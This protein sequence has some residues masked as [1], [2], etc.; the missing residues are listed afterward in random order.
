MRR[1][2]RVIQARATGTAPTIVRE[3]RPHVA[4]RKAS[5]PSTPIG[6]AVSAAV[7]GC[8]HRLDQV[9]CFVICSVVLLWWLAQRLQVRACS[10]LS[11]SHYGVVGLYTVTSSKPP[12]GTANPTPTPCVWPVVTAG[13]GERQICTWLANNEQTRLLGACLAQLAHPGDIIALLGDLGVGKTCVARGFLREFFGLPDLDVPS[14][15]FLFCVA[16]GEATDELAQRA[17]VPGTPVFHMDP[18]RLKQKVSNLVDFER[19]FRSG[20]CLIEWPQMLGAALYNDTTPGR[21]EIHFEG[22]GPQGQGRRVTLRAVSSPRWEDA[23]S[24]W[25]ESGCMPV[26]QLA[27]EGVAPSR[28]EPTASNLV[29]PPA[30]DP[31]SWKVVGIETSCDDTAAAVVTGAGAVLSNVIA[32]QGHVHLPFRGVKPDTAQAAHEEN[33]DRVVQA[34]LREAGCSPAE[35]TAVAVTVGPGLGLCLRVGVQKAVALA[36]EYAL[37]IV[38][39][40]H[41]EAHALVS[42]LPGPD[43]DPSAAVQFPALILLV[44]GGHNML[45]VTRGVGDHTVLGST[46]DDSAG[47]AFDKVARLLG[48]EAVPGG[49]VLERMAAAGDRTVYASNMPIPLSKGHKRATYGGNFSFSGLK[50]CVRLLVESEEQRI[51]VQ[52][53]ENE[54]AS[55]LERMRRNVA[56]CFQHVSIEHLVQVVERVLPQVTA[57]EPQIRHFVL[58]G[59]VAANTALRARFERFAEAAGLMLVCPPPPL[60]T[61]NGVMVA[62]TGLERLRLGLYEPPP[63]PTHDFCAMDVR[64]RWPLG[65]SVSLGCCLKRRGRL[66]RTTSVSLVGEPAVGS[67]W[68]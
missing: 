41:M 7:A 40:H 45:V 23:L 67:G 27:R 65:D 35:L 47:E 20:I 11:K 26:P 10:L 15:T 25:L 32:S 60:C 9:A 55:Q 14:P 17:R 49:P 56:A 66:P 52:Y 6:S 29:V 46:M 8:P 36:A 63:L 33:I 51:R 64:P 48:V 44:S 28:A 43:M 53:G 13:R 24:C 5:C 12:H 61:D 39:V 18:F 54:W 50:N 68:D 62:W 22:M 4:L 38:P 21:L 42:R 2:N 30:G 1:G 37:P 19:A 31:A 57:A 59:G 3:V 58:A 16:Y 34:A